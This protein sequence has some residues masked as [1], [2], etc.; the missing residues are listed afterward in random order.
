MEL[1]RAALSGRLGGLT[2]PAGSR[3]LP[4]PEQGLYLIVENSYLSGGVPCD[5][6][7][8]GPGTAT[9]PLAEAEAGPGVGG[10][11]ETQTEAEAETETEAGAEIG[12][13][14]GVETGAGADAEIGMGMGRVVGGEVPG[15]V[16]GL[17]R[18]MK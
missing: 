14:A 15:G 1:A 11:T 8:G 2:Y 7:E 18:S 6:A 3:S 13:E 9:E 12:A 5:K 17:M 16:K 10:E 4:T